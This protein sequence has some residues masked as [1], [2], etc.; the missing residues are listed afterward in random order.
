MRVFVFYR[1]L[2]GLN[3]DRSQILVPTARLELAQLSPLPPQD[4][5][6]TNSTTSANA[7]NAILARF[8]MCIGASW[9]VLQKCRLPALGIKARIAR[10]PRE[11]GPAVRAPGN[12]GPVQERCRQPEAWTRPRPERTEPPGPG[13]PARPERL[14]LRARTAPRYPRRAAGGPGSLASGRR[15]EWNRPCG[16]PYRP[17]RWWTGKK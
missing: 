10:A 16:G 3:G 7:K 12:S 17:A 6:S 4:S 15:R 2:T 14:L 9:A 13:A 5:V 8:L 1:S 11:P